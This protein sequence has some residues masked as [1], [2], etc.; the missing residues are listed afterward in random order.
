MGFELEVQSEFGEGT[1]F[2]IHVPA[3]AVE[4]PAPAPRVPAES[5]LPRPESK[6]ITARSKLVLV[7]DDKLDARLLLSQLLEE[8]GCRVITADSGEAALRHAREVHPDLILLDLMM[9]EMNGWQVLEKLKSD[10]AV[11]GIPVVIA[12]VIAAENRGT[13]LGA[14]DVLQKPVTQED[15][16][17]VLHRLPHSKVLV[18][19]DSESDRLLMKTALEAD[20]VEVQTAVSGRDGLELLQR[21]TPDVVALDLMMPEMDGFTFLERL[22]K[23]PAHEHLPVVIVTAKDLSSEDRKRINHHAQAIHKKADDLAFDL[24]RLLGS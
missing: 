17:R 22:R 21:F 19:D 18:V 1:T 7:I 5:A 3:Q 6:A 15:I 13:L 20:G 16:Q 24:K 2:S 10:P 9:P 11:S 12:S 14:L 4:V 8:C 23:N